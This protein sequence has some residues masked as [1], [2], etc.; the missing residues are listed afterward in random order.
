MYFNIFFSLVN[1]LD[2]LKASQDGV[3]V[4]TIGR[5]KENGHSFSQFESLFTVI[6]ESKIEGQKLKVGILQKDKN[7]G[8]MIEEWSSFFSNNSDEYDVIDAAPMIS[9]LLASKDAQELVLLV[10]MN[11]FNFLLLEIN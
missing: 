7:E 10:N 8:P 6:K 5:D 4:V 9:Y 11:L 1:I 3:E 2:N